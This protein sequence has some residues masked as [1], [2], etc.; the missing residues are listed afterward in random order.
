MRNIYIEPEPDAYIK[1][2]VQ[3]KTGEVG[4]LGYIKEDEDGRLVVYETFLVP[5]YASAS[6]VDFE[7]LGGLAYGVEKAVNDGCFDD[8]TPFVGWFKWHSHGNLGAFWSSTDDTINAWFA[9]ADI[10]WFV[11]Y[12]VNR[13]GESK[14]RMEMYN[15]EHHGV[16]IPQ[17]TMDCGSLLPYASLKV[18][19]Q[20]TK[21]LKEHVHERPTKG[22][23]SNGTS[24]HG[25]GTTTNSQTKSGDK[26]KSGSSSTQSRTSSAPGDKVERALAVRDAT[27]SASDAAYEAADDPNLWIPVFPGTWDDLPDGSVLVGDHMHVTE[28][29]LRAM[30]DAGYTLVRVKVGDDK[31]DRYLIE[32]DKIPENMEPQVIDETEVAN[33]GSS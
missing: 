12:V 13:K 11:D 3:A 28:N 8:D 14:L 15:V 17:V 31:F 30:S 22:R 26:S 19:D 33:A 27:S 9:E 6:E 2:C 4:G 5:Q 10:P 29:N 18:W 1:A 20:V 16:Y 23:S 25:A 21:D 24:K 7:D 32:N